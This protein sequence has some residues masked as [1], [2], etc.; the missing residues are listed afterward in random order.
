MPKL[1]LSMPPPPQIQNLHFNDF[2]TTQTNNDTLLGRLVLAVSK[3][4]V[5]VS[6]IYVCPSAY[7]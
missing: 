6:D 3:Q 5:I 7:E 4:H 2:K 1:S